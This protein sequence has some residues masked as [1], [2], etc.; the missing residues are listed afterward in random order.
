[1]EKITTSDSTTASSLVRIDLRKLL[2]RMLSYWWLFGICL[3]IALGGAHIYLRYATY[4]Y[5]ARAIMLVKDAGRSG[6]ISTQDILLADGAL[7]GRK[8]MDNEIQILNSHSLMEK[9]VDR[10]GLEISYYRIGQ[11]K[12]TELYTTTPFVLDSFHFS[13]PAEFGYNFY[14]EQ[15][16]YQTF[17]FKTSLEDPGVNYSYGVPFENELGWFKI[18]RNPDIAVI[19]GLYRL[20]IGKKEYV[21]NRYKSRVQVLRIGD[22][23]NSSVLELS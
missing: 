21:A 1:M 23:N 22:Q 19:K 7:S 20:Q 2:W 4:Q 3:A 8:T 5:A 12:E 11:F 13:K 18:S 16:D 6:N 17:L 9:V 14:V 10:L 15:G